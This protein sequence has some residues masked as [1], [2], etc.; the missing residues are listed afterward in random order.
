MSI[1]VDKFGFIKRDT[2]R[3]INLDPLQ[4]GGILTPEAR[5]A[6]LEWG[7]GYSVYDYCM[8]SLNQI[9]TPPLFDFVHKALPEFLGCDQARLTNGAREAIF[10]AMNAVC[11]DG[12]WVV[13]DGNAH[14]SS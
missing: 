9:K 3:L 14:Y 10:A 6:L 2:P 1:N 4:T 11:R 8:S 7:D 12:D 13:M 5:R